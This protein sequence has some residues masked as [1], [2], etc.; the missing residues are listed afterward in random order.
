[1]PLIRFNTKP[2][3]KQLAVFG[4]T[5]AVVFGAIGGLAL[6]HSGSVPIA[7]VLWSLAAVVPAVGWFAPAVLRA[8]YVGLAVPVY[9]VG[10]VVSVVLLAGVYYGIF[11]PI[12]LVLRLLG[13]DPMARQ[14]PAAEETCW[15][16]RSG[17]QDVRR[18]FRQF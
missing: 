5:W 10:V 8:V 14:F 9:P 2:S 17:V 16:P 3:N 7:I 12:G 11:T 13:R 6:H 15:T 18:Y 4:V 1:V